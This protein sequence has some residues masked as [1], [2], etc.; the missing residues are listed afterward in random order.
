ME[1]FSRPEMRLLA[2]WEMVSLNVA[3]ELLSP[4]RGCFAEAAASFFLLMGST[5]GG[6]PWFGERVTLRT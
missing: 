4:L 3:G 1:C 2:K 5:R 6:G